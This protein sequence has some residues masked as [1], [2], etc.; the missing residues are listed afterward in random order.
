M[1]TTDK[2]N[3]GINDPQE[4]GQNKAYLVLSSKELAKGFIRPVREYYIHKTCRTITGMSKKIQETY[5]RD[6][7]FYSATF[8]LN[9]ENHYPVGEFRWEG[10]D[11]LV[12]S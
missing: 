9:C 1:T 4:N 12:G 3:Q 5:A 2:N 6:P 10:T 11:E 7:K 8:C